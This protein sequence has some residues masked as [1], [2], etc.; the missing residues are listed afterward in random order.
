MDSEVPVAK[1][2]ILL[3]PTRAIVRPPGT[4]YAEALTRRVPPP[5]VDLSLA[6]S[7]HAD[8][9]A[10]LRGLGLEVLELASDEAHPDAVFVQDRACVLDG[11]AIIG[12]SA[13]DSRRGETTGLIEILEPFFPVVELSPPA[14]LD[15]GDVLVTQEALYVGLSERSN[16]A[17]VEQL[18]ELLGRGRIVEGVPL[19]SGL[20]H[21]LSGCSWLGNDAL[22]AIESLEEFARTRGFPTVRVPAAEAPAA[23]A[24]VLGNDVLLPAGYPQT[25]S[26]IER[27]GRR[28]HAVS[29]GEFEKRDGGVTCLSVLY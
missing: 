15:W 17:A 16:R 24:L 14:C 20:L 8:Y 25:R 18:R 12:P 4:S 1:R 13:V 26:R 28:V 9:V 29:V 19:P 10:C 3:L 5:P 2:G 27:L 22:L 23:N 6:C 21:L 11:R 7:Q